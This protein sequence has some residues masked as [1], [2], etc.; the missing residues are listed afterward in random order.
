M[1]AL[2]MHQFE[3]FGAGGGVPTPP[4]GLE[5]FASA[6]VDDMSTLPSCGGTSSHSSPGSDSSGD[7]LAAA[8]E[9]RKV[10]FSEVVEDVEDAEWAAEAE[11]PAIRSAA[12]S[13]S[14]GEFVAEA[15]A[16]VKVFCVHCGT[17]VASRFMKLQQFKFCAYC[18]KEHP[19]GLITW[20]NAGGEGPKRS[21][22]AVLPRES[23]DEQLASV[24]ASS[25]CAEAARKESAPAPS[26]SSSG[27]CSR[28]QGV[29]S[30]EVPWHVG[31]YAPPY[32][33]SHFTTRWRYSDQSQRAGPLHVSIGQ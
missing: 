26:S 22:E 8:P 17:R 16:E 27:F 30:A 14:A 2:K 25:H 18:G 21:E 1:V 7:D 23:V 10:S 31:G 5:S 6:A 33:A 28:G 4:P 12:E 19:P 9:R 3:K 32:A 15:G 20:A 29:G 13:V 11:V 24:R